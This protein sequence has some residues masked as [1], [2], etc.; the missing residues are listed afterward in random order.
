MRKTVFVEVGQGLVEPRVRRVEVGS[1]RKSERSSRGDEL[2]EVLGWR[3]L[4]DDEAS[5]DLEV[6]VGIGMIWRWRK[7]RGVG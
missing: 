3:R 4:L 1:R 2:V 7:L 5:F 6:L